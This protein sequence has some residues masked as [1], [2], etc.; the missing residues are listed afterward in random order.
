MARKRARFNLQDDAA[1][2]LQGIK[3]NIGMGRWSNRRVPAAEIADQPLNLVKRPGS[4]AGGISIISPELI[5]A[6]IGVSAVRE[7]NHCTLWRCI[8][9]TTKGIN[10]LLCNCCPAPYLCFLRNIFNR[11]Q[12]C[13]RAGRFSG[14][15]ERQAQNDNQ[16][17]S[18]DA[19]HNF[20][21]LHPLHESN[22]PR[23]IAFSKH[24]AS[25]HDL[26]A[27]LP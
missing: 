24:L 19:T 21:P 26:F 1:A 18:K 22:M 16:Y 7:R 8:S 25:S 23:P 3:Q 12:D 4:H 6:S 10:D 20:A 27:G 11:Q 15:Q 14:N 17:R 9:G 5:T 2:S 13:L